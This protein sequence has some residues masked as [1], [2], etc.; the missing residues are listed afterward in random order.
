MSRE[1]DIQLK[2]NLL[3]IGFT[4][5]FSG[6][7]YGHIVPAVKAAA[8]LDFE[9]HKCEVWIINAPEGVNKCQSF[10]MAVIGQSKK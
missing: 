3:I 6:P 5:L 1:Q 8:T 4:L 2:K 9:P 10:E 7:F